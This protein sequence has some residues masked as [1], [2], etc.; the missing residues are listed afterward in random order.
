MRWYDDLVT[1]P[2]SRRAESDIQRVGSIG[3]SKS[4]LSAGKSSERCLELDEVALKYERPA[5]HHGRDCPQYLISL[6]LEEMRIPEERDRHAG[7]GE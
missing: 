2:D 1:R 3:N 4:V 5:V 6:L 7:G